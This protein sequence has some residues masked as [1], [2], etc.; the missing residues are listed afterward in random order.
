MHDAD[1]WG[2]KRRSAF[3]SPQ[4]SSPPAGAITNASRP[5]ATFLDGDDDTHLNAHTFDSSLSLSSSHDGDTSPTLLHVPNTV[6]ELTRVI[7]ANANADTA[8]ATSNHHALEL[9][10]LVGRSAVDEASARRYTGASRMMNAR[11]IDEN[12]LHRDDNN[13][14]NNNARKNNAEISLLSQKVHW[15][16]L[17]YS[18]LRRKLKSNEEDGA[19]WSLRYSRR[20]VVLSN[21]WLGIVLYATRLVVVVR[22]RRRPTGYIG[23]SLLKALTFMSPYDGDASPSSSRRMRFLEALIAGGVDGFAHAAVFFVAAAL[24]YRAHAWKRNIGFALSTGY[25]VWLTLASRRRT[26]RSTRA[27]GADLFLSS[28]SVNIFLNVLHF[29]MRY[30]Y[31]HGLLS[32][33]DTRVL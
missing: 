26:V 12:Q 8:L 19:R 18:R 32:F 17:E 23:R 10:G 14:D 2:A 15:L 5:R 33:S 21:L 30:Y 25:S 27:S 20:I 31:L 13:P 9:T 7:E 22:R 28:H 6:K 4:E 24:H 3:H 1:A 29:G 16:Q 11:S